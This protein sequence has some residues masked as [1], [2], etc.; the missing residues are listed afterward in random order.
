MTI[1]TSRGKTFEAAWADT[2]RTTGDL[3]IEI[4]DDGRLLS[5]I[6]LDFEGLD[7]VTRTAEGQAEIQ[8]DGYWVLAGMTRDAVSRSVLITLRKE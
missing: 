3:L 4:E 7:A 6:A 2:V 5:A 8:Y 1:T